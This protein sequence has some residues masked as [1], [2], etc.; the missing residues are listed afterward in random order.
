MIVEAFPAAQLQFWGLPH[1]NYSGSSGRIN[2][3]KIIKAISA[4]VKID[5]KTQQLM[6]DIP[7]AL[8]ALI[9]CFAAIAATTNSFEQADYSIDDGMIAVLCKP[10]YRSSLPILQSPQLRA[11]S[12]PN[13]FRSSP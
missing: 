11:I 1:Q 3:E 10:E 12:P 13:L 8:D 6:T 2:R 7:D 4:F 9:A 5:F